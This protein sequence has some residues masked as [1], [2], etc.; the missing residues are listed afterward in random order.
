MRSLLTY[1]FINKLT[2]GRQH[3]EFFK[4]PFF[5]CIFLRGYRRSFAGRFNIITEGSRK[6]LARFISKPIKNLTLG[7]WLE[8][9][10][11]TCA[12]EY[13]FA[14]VVI[15]AFHFR[16]SLDLAQFQ[17][18]N[19]EFSGGLYSINGNYPKLKKI[20]CAHRLSFQP[21]GLANPD[22]MIPFL[23]SDVKPNLWV[24]R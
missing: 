4:N 11:I 2:D 20:I 6:H 1:N 5:I 21:E 22:T 16:T 15:A 13:R 7:Q 17:K 23:T 19:K 24:S 12:R 8:I 3:T 10:R 14:A 18:F 9:V